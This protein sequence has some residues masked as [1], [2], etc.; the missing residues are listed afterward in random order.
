MT[1]VQTCA[2]QIYLDHMA[3]IAR[4]M[5]HQ[6]ADAVGPWREYLRIVRPIA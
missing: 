2:L 6:Y 1:G 4:V 5:A 3:Q